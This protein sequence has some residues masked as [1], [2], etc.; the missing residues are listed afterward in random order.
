MTLRYF[1][2]PAPTHFT[3][4]F[5]ATSSHH[6]GF[7]VM[8]YNIVIQKT[9]DWC[10][11]WKQSIGRHYNVAREVIIIRQYWKCASREMYDAQSQKKKVWDE[12]EKMRLNEINAVLCKITLILTNFKHISLPPAHCVC[13]SFDR[14]AG[15]YY[16][17]IRCT[18]HSILWLYVKIDFF[19][20]VWISLKRKIKQNK[21]K[22]V[23]IL[24]C[25]EEWI[26]K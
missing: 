21:K 24:H 5:S 26:N 23:F 1:F 9:I 11:L 25:E 15:Q 16:F 4:S 6:R 3:S 13:C 14:S 20:I 7:A 19:F 18:L 22:V 8:M 10:L 12:I 17:M 2:F